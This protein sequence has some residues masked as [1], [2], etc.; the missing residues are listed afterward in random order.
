ML[1]LPYYIADVRF[2]VDYSIQFIGGVDNPATKS[3]IFQNILN[4]I[5]NFNSFPSIVSKNVDA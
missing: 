5:S 2:F 4:Q 3:C 1:L